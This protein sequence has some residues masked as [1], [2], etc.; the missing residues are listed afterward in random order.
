MTTEIKHLTK[1]LQHFTAGTRL[2][3]NWQGRWLVILTGVI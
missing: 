1:E 2:E 3:N